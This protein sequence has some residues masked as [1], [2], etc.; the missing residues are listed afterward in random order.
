MEIAREKSS[1]LRELHVADGGLSYAVTLMLS[2]RGESTC[3]ANLEVK[4]AF[5]LQCVFGTR[6][7]RTDIF[8]REQTCG[9]YRRR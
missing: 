7:T 6:T 4:H 2:I 3:E 8:S 5:G 9:M 1:N